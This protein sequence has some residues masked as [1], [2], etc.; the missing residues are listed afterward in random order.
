MTLGPCR[1]TDS[2]CQAYEDQLTQSTPPCD[3]DLAF[4]VITS[5][6]WEYFVNR[7]SVSLTLVRIAISTFTCATALNAIYKLPALPFLML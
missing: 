6:P 7:S 3:D 2:I 4:I 5:Y 1:S